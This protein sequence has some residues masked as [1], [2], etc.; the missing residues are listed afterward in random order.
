MALK[1]IN[2]LSESLSSGLTSYLG[3]TPTRASEPLGISLRITILMIGISLVSACGGFGNKTA[4]VKGPDIT[5]P[6]VLVDDD[7]VEEPQATDPDEIISYG[8]WQKRLRKQ[9]EKTPTKTEL[10]KL[11]DIDIEEAQPDSDEKASY[12]EWLKS[13][14]QDAAKSGA[15]SESSEDL[16]Y[17][18]WLKKRSEASKSESADPESE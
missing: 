17:E 7:R 13:R 18:D 10:E 16:S 5:V 11:Q 3:K 8:E 14:T 9:A 15:D 4:D 2:K 6:P 1:L 12:E